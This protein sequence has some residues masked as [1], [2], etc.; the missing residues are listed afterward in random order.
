MPLDFGEIYIYILSTT[1]LTDG[2]WRV[3]KMGHG[4]HG[5]WGGA[6]GVGPIVFYLF[7]ML[8]LGSTLPHF[9]LG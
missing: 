1:Q 8:L 9:T 2:V 5:G 3:W 7:L 4:G 6:E